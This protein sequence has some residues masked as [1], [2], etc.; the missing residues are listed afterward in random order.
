MQ[1]SKFGGSVRNSSVTGSLGPWSIVFGTMV[2]LSAEGEVFFV[3]SRDL[4]DSTF[5]EACRLLALKSWLDPSRL[6]PKA[7]PL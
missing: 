5:S 2:P 6:E 7:G 1:S 3:Q 4:A